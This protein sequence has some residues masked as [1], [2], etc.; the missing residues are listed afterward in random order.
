MDEPNPGSRNARSHGARIRDSGP[1][2]ET[3][4][5]GN[6]GKPGEPVKTEIN[7]KKPGLESSN[8][9]LSPRGKNSRWTRLPR[10]EVSGEVSYLKCGRHQFCRCP[11]VGRGKGHKGSEREHPQ[12]TEEQAQLILF[13]P[14]YPLVQQ[15][16]NPLIF[17]PLF[18]NFFC[19]ITTSFPPK[20][21]HF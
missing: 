8:L 17:Y 11:T 14:F 7:S 16:I 3:R 12:R 5:S 4:S 21:T 15:S 10:R 6:A 20:S 13:H 2:L 1:G 9:T 19:R 18:S